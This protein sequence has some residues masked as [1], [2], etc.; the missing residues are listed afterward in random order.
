MKK[1]AIT[2][3]IGSGKSLVGKYISQL[4]YDV[5]SCDSIYLEISKTT[6]YITQLEKMF[7]EAVVQGEIDRKVLSQTV[8]NSPEKR[9]QLNK[10]SHPLI[11]QT[12]AKR[13][14][15]S[16]NEFVFAEV[17]LLF[18]G[19]YQNEFDYVLVVLRSLDA[20]V[21]SLMSRDTTTKE[22]CLKR[23]QA[24]FDYNKAKLENSFPKHCIFIEN[25]SDIENLQKNIIIALKNIIP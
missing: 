12:L 10:L 24:Q 19:N 21:T 1:I 8:F 25:N 23:I 6:S 14:E 5:F 22:E 15:E 16:K 11:M 7:P 2:G 13:M 18:E 9:A 4:G 17:P 3:G 20:R